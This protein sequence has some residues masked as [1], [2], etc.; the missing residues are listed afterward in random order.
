M[1]LYNFLIKKVRKKRKRGNEIIIKIIPLEKKLKV[2]GDEGRSR[3]G[4]GGRGAGSI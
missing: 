3:D 1:Y 2:G 4:G